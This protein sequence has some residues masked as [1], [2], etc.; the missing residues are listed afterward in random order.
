MSSKNYRIGLVGCGGM[1]RHHLK[2]IAS[3]PNGECVALCDVFEEN[4]KKT[5]E[6]Y[7]I[8]SHFTDFEKMYREADLDLVV[9]ATQTRDH[10]A[11]TL[12]AAR[13]GVNILCEKPISIDPAEADEMVAAA[14]EAG[15]K[16]SI[17]QQNHVNAF[18]IKAQELIAEGLIGDVVLVRGRN[19][20][21]RKSGNEFMEMGT[22]ITNM[23]MCAAGPPAWVSG[24]V[25]VDNRLAEIGDIMEAKEMSPRDRDSGLVL[26][27]RVLAQYGFKSGVSGE[28]HFLPFTTRNNRNYGFDVIGTEGQLAARASDYGESGP[29]LWHLDRPMEGYPSDLDW[30]PVEAAGITIEEPIITMYKKMFEAIEGDTE[31]P[32]SGTEG[33]LALEMILGI[34]ESHRQNGGRVNLPMAERSHPL[35]RWRTE[36]G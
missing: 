17:N 36:E 10:H 21:G 13:H 2:S 23:M 8:E 31:P 6:Q 27:H 30:K 3:V 9:V 20:A 18:T 7:G 14:K 11:P 15:V 1:G 4:L 24:S 34:Y 28:I 26:G 32:S 12:A 5:G 25:F 19:K 35:E 33:M 16:F 22:H 29:I